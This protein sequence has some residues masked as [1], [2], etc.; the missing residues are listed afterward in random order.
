MALHVH[1]D[2]HHV[3]YEEMASY[4]DT[5]VAG[6]FD[7]VDQWH[8]R[9]LLLLLSCACVSTLRHCTCCLLLVLPCERGRI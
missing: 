4:L 8:V 6:K 1:K 3:V 9:V 5:A 7:S 2:Q